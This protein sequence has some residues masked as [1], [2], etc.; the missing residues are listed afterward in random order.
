ML[1][2]SSATATSFNNNAT[3]ATG[4]PACD[5]CHE[6]VT[7]VS[8]CGRCLNATYC[9][10]TCQFNAWKQHKESCAD[11]DILAELDNATISSRA[12]NAKL[13]KKYREISEKERLLFSRMYPAPSPNLAFEVY[14]FPDLYAGCDISL[15]FVGG[16]SEKNGLRF[17]D[18]KRLCLELNG[19]RKDLIWQAWANDTEK[20]L[21]IEVAHMIANERE[22][23]GNAKV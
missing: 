13:E 21:R 8:K 7:T 3:T 17:R 11:S 19:F 22:K 15:C 23:A 18:V 20:R 9:S 1:N 6:A 10:R 12:K 4:G 16:D 14:A 5:G 2:C